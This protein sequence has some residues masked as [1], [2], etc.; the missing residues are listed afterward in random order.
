MRKKTIES[1]EE[2]TSIDEWLMSYTPSSREKEEQNKLK[3][4]PTALGINLAIDSI[5]ES[6]E[7]DILTNES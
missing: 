6:C 1:V 4:D 5:R 7:I 2:F 3:G